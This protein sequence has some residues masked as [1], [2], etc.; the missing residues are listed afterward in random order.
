MGVAYSRYADDLYFS[1]NS[2]NVLGELFSKLR[3]YVS[4]QSSPRLQINEQK[5]VFTSRKR[6]KIVTGLVLTSDHKISI[7]L[8]RKRV[9]KSLV[10]Q[11]LHEKL[12]SA[13]IQKLGGWIAYTRSVE[14]TFVATIER[15]YHISLEAEF[16]KRANRPKSKPIS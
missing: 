6:R 14:P 15:K 16:L 12:G 11:L 3:T 2:P 1:T 5:T 10:F 9:L 8:K 7:G 13:Q 4:E